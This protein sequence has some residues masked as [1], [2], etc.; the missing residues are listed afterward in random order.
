MF[1]FFFFFFFDFFFFFLFFLCR[2]ELFVFC[3]RQSCGFVEPKQHSFVSL[4]THTMRVRRPARCLSRFGKND[5]L[6]T[7]TVQC[8]DLVQDKVDRRW[9]KLT[10]VP[11]GEVEL[12]IHAIGWGKAAPPPQQQQQQQVCTLSGLASPTSMLTVPSL[13]SPLLG[14]WGAPPQGQW[15]APPQGQWGAVSL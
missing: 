6:G 12:E 14:Q 11:R 7:A 5:P 10:N 8:N 13:R 1:F 3:T 4:L 2:H 9:I 15:G